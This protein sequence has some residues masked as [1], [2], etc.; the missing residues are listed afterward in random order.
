M[1]GNT[2]NLRS[3]TE[4]LEYS[5]TMKLICLL[6]VH[7]FLTITANELCNE[8]KFPLRLL[9]FLPC[10]TR[11]SIK[12]CDKHTLSAVEYAV[13]R[14]NEDKDTLNCFNVE[15]LPLHVANPNKVCTAI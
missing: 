13:A 7:I 5:A 10:S 1:F 2:I 6:V 12:H 4:L 9:I 11:H 15:L 14:V 8:G 3:N